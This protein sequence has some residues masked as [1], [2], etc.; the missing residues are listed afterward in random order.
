M[1][2]R[3]AIEVYVPNLVERARWQRLRPTVLAWVEKTLPCSATAAVAR[4]RVATRYCIW[5]E[6][7]GFPIDPEQI[8]T[9]DLIE[10]W[11]ASADVTVNAKG[12]YRAHLSTVA[13]ANTRKA[14]WTPT[15]E[16]MRRAT[17]RDPYTGAEVDGYLRLIP[18]QATAR[19]RW[20]F[21]VILHVGLAWGLTSSEMFTLNRSDITERDGMVIAKVGSRRVP[22]RARYA[23]DILRLVK[24]SE[25]ERLLGDHL[26]GHRRF[27][28]LIEEVEIPAYQPAL[29]A[30]RLRTTW[31]VD[32][33]S[34]GNLTL[35]E[36]QRI[37]GLRSGR[38]LDDL[39]PHLPVDEDTYLR[40]AV[41]R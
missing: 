4:V 27:D 15:P 19:R 2:A 10:A 31:L 21:D 40:R 1:D 33:L 17:L 37:S 30:R 36:F 14:I 35:A 32:V 18:L 5:C 7:N 22:A 20:V 41:G 11:F 8:L 24:Q 16:P 9:E 3:D 13:K 23:A 29:R 38:V 34:D 12:T 39:V 6:D 28:R 26:R 25:G